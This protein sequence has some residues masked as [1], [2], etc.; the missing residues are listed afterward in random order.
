MLKDPK[1]QNNNKN[2]QLSTGS[3]LTGSFATST[4][5]NLTIESAGAFDNKHAI[6]P[7]TGVSNKKEK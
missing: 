1:R 3:S 7:G 2:D 5:S 4:S 6:I